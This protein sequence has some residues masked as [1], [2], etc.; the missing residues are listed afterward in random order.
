MKVGFV[1]SLLGKYL[2]SKSLVKEEPVRIYLEPLGINLVRKAA[3]FAF[4]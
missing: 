4:F 1:P 2:Y 3:Y